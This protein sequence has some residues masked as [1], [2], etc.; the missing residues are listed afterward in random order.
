LEEGYG[1]K[2]ETNEEEPKDKEVQAEA[3]KSELKGRE[4]AL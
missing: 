2:G 3:A 4:R 1:A